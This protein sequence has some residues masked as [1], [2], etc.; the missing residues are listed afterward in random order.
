MLDH[1]LAR[2]PGRAGL[3][4]RGVSGM[5]QGEMLRS[6]VPKRP[7]AEVAGSDAVLFPELRR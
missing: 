5:F 1:R 4:R 3:A 7:S 2:T 6:D